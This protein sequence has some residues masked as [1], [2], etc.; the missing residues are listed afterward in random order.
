M[1]GNLFI[2]SGGTGTKTGA[3]WNNA[4]PDIPVPPVCGNSY[5]VAGGTYNRPNTSSQLWNNTCTASNPIF[6]YKAVDC[7]LVS[8]PYCGTVNP[9]AIAGWLTSYGT[10]AALFVQPQGSNLQATTSS[11]TFMSIC[12]NYYT[13][14]GV[15]PITGTPTT[16]GFGFVWRNPN[17]SGGMLGVG[18]GSASCTQAPSTTQ[19]NH[20]TIKHSE[21]DGVDPQYGFNVASCSRTSNVVTLNMATVPTNWL[22]GNNIDVQNTVPADF[23][24]GSSGRGVVIQSLSGTTITYNQTGLDE[25]CT[26]PGYATRNITLGRPIQFNNQSQTFD[27]ITVTDNYIHDVMD[28]SFFLNTTNL[29]F[30]RNWVARNRNTFTWHANGLVVQDGGTFTSSGGIV[31]NPGTA[32]TGFGCTIANNVW[33]NITGTQVVG[34]LSGTSK[35]NDFRLYNNTFFCSSTAGPPNS[36]ASPQC[37]VSRLT[38]DNFTSTTTP[39]ITNAAVIGNSF[40]GGAVKNDYRIEFLNSTC[41][42]TTIQNNVWYIPGAK[43]DF[44]LGLSTTENHNTVLGASFV[45]SGKLVDATDSIQLNTTVNPFLSVTAP[46]NFNIV[47]ATVAT[48]LTDG[49]ALPAPYNVDQI[50]AARSTSPSGWTRGALAFNAAGSP[51]AAPTNLTVVVN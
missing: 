42:T 28:G 45:T 46:Y 19:L 49:V 7:S 1:A 33:E 27:S 51:P 18:S 32:G 16:S 14:D 26:A 25:V 17:P 47:S 22:V 11:N 2:V 39:C 3:D 48:H 12:G 30:E 5:F 44:N 43:L 6:I 41:S 35:I 23:N 20:I 36:A 8:A 4:L 34:N 50:G 13:I 24:T 21:F 37:G 40:Y 10:L 9:G 31:C 38:G 15:T 29:D